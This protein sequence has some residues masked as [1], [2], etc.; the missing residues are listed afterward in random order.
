MNS[1]TKNVL[2]LLIKLSTIREFGGDLIIVNDGFIGIDLRFDE[3][4]PVDA[5]SSIKK[6]IEQKRKEMVK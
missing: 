4:I 6:L 3:P 1:Q 5:L 2:D